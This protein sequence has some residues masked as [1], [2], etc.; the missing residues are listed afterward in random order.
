MSL[1]AIII[2]EDTGNHGQ[3]DMTIKLGDYI[4]VI[5]IKAEDKP[6]SATESDSNPAFAQIRNK[7][8]SDKYRD[9]P[10]SKLFEVG[11]VFSR[12]ERNLVQANWKEV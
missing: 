6:V 11:L 2:P 4:Y 3:V 1:N 5:E 12:E 10:C 7:G 9:E 8:Y